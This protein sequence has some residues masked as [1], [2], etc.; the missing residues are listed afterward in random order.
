MFFLDISKLLC[1]LLEFTF[2]LLFVFFVHCPLLLFPSYLNQRITIIELHKRG[3][4]NVEIARLFEIPSKRIGG[5]FFDINHRITQRQQAPPSVMMW[6][7]ICATN[8]KGITGLHSKQHQ[9]QCINIDTY[10]LEKVF[11]PWAQKHFGSFNRVLHQH[12]KLKSLGVS[13]KRV[14]QDFSPQMNA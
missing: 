5:L 3:K 8:R 14:V 9:N 13:P 11:I 1:S 12:T 2:V 10:A 7:R 4:N 6:R